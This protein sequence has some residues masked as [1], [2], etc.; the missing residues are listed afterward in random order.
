MRLGLYLSAQH[1]P[2][3]DMAAALE[4]HLQQVRLARQ[5]GFAAV[6]APQHFL[7][8]PYQML[9]PLPLLA[10]LAAESGGMTLGT[11]ILLLSLLNPVEVAET[12]ATLDVLCG[13]RLVLGVGEGYRPQERA[14]FGIDA[15]PRRSLSERLDVVTRLLEGEEVSA[16]GEGYRLDRARLALRPL[17]RPRPPVWMAANRDGAVR[18]A[19]RLSDAWLLNPHAT[20]GHLERQMLLFAAERGSPPDDVPIVREVCVAE[21]DSAALA[22][23]APHLA[24]KYGAYV[25]WGQS[26][27]MPAGD[28]LRRDWDDLRR[29]RFVIGSP[30]RVVAELDEL[31]ERLGATLVLARVQWPG[32][33][34]DL[35]MRSIRLLGEEVLP[36]LAPVRDLRPRR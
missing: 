36:R 27:A 34:P 25:R 22:D 17:A 16:R 14:A 13:G 21:T 28:T 30:A 26:E 23:A 19:A 15:P 7:S 33:P 12:A 9:Q 6:F 5:S 32:A 31:R 4:E 20:L 11:G 10:R 8:H 29:E 3:A 35:A 2:E 24:A 18:R 1:P